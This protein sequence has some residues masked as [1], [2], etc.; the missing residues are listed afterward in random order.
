M[1]ALSI[2]GSGLLA[3]QAQF[4]ATANNIANLNTPDYET[5]SVDLVSAPDGDG[6]EIGGVQFTNQPVDLA[7]QMVN[8]RRSAI[9]YDANA[10]VVMTQDQMYGS[11]L[12]VLDNQNQNQD[13]PWDND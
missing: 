7:T 9:M 1:D 5:Q 12:N 13:F 4:N 3:A 2:A 8:L 6:V 10:M 11:L